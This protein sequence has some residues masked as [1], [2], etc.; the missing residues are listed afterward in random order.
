MYFIAYRACGCLSNS[1]LKGFIQSPVGRHTYPLCHGKYI[2]RLVSIFMKPY[3]R[4]I[5]LNLHFCLEQIGIFATSG[6]EPNYI[7]T[8][9]QF[10][11]PSYNLFQLYTALSMNS[12]VE[13][14]MKSYVD[15]LDNQAT[16]LNIILLFVR[17]F[18]KLKFCPP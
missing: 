17:L 10:F 8:L 5:R 12:H 1:F 7:V 4:K 15:Y 14:S 9:Y 2:K 6:I 3:L 11:V 18:E 16:L 13:L